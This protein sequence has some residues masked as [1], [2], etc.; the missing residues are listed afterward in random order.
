MRIIFSCAAAAALAGCSA[1]PATVAEGIVDIDQVTAAVE[2]ELAAAALDRKAV[3]GGVGK[4]GALTDLDLTQ[5]RGIGVDGTASVSAPAGAGVFSFSPKLGVTGT[6]TQSG[7][8]QF[9]TNLAKA[10]AKYGT[11]CSGSDPSETRMGLANWVR[12]AFAAVDKKA[13]TGVTFT[14]QFEILATASARF[15][16]TLVPVVNPITADAGPGGSLDRTNRFT[17]ALA[18]PEGPKEPLKVTIVGGV[19]GVAGGNSLREGT[20]PSGE[21]VQ[22]RGARAPTPNVTNPEFYYLLN[23]KSPLIRGPGF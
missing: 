5:V 19:P 20:L 16:Y 4:W 7:H 15:G 11:Q 17:V 13:L 12:A 9:A 1:F 10:K 21:N 6:Y 22:S 2:C 18:P 14:R 8:V 23:R 3:E